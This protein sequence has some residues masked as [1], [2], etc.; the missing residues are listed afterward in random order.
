MTHWKPLSDTS[1]AMRRAALLERARQYFS[2]QGLLAVDTP[3][4]GSYAVTDP[5]IENLRVRTRPGK[6]SYLQTSPEIYMKRLLASGF[7]DI[8]SICRVFRDGESGQR[9]LPEF[10]MAEW[11]RIVNSISTPSSRTASRFMGAHA[12]AGRHSVQMTPLTVL[13][14]RDCVPGV[15]WHRRRCVLR[16]HRG[17]RQSRVRRMTSAF[18][19]GRLQMTRN[20]ALDLIMSNGCCAQTAARPAD[21]RPTI[22]SRTR[23]RWPDSEPER[24]QGCR[25]VRGLLPESWSWR[26]ATSN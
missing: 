22:S 12:W 21:R 9:H 4:L 1:V 8:Y 5:N 11:Y 10:T 19:C 24:Q 16:Q 23:R 18:A 26:T 13:H 17:S 2:D 14:Y 20:A 3:A 7:P 6:D 25:P 15:R